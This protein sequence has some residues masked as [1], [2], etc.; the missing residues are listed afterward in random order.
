MSQSYTTVKTIWGLGL[1]ASRR[2]GGVY[3]P[4]LYSTVNEAM[5]IP[6]DASLRTPSDDNN[7]P[8]LNVLMIGRGGHRNAIGG[9]SDSL[10]DTLTPRINAVTLFEAMPF[11]A[12]PVSGG[13]V[14][15]G[16]NIDDFCLEKT[17]TY[18]GVQY[19]C[20]YGMFLNTSATGTDVTIQEITVDPI[21][22]SISKKAYE[23]DS[24]LQL[25]P[26]PLTLSTGSTNN[27]T[28]VYLEVSTPFKLTFSADLVTAIMAASSIA[29]GDDLR[30]SVIS[31]MAICY[32]VK[33]TVPGTNWGTQSFTTEALWCSPFTFISTYNKLQYQTSGFSYNFALGQSLP[34]RT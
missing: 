27:A 32:S 10:T 26:T 11:L 8:E 5:S 19:K 15:A 13:T 2:P 23:F 34:Y 3:S 28:N 9:S 20:Y 7:K 17:E 12:I 6:S 25:N 22:R 30:Y 24:A 21:D 33:E 29:H 14:P 31:E 4:K 16:I 18:S 1:E